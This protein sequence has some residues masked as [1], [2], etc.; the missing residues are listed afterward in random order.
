MLRMFARVCVKVLAFVALC[1][2]FHPPPEENSCFRLPS[3]PCI[4]QHKVII[5]KIFGANAPELENVV[6]DNIFPKKEEE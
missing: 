2:W 6:A 4:G 1:D 3:T 5:G